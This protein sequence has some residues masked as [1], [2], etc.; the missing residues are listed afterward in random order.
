MSI[1]KAENHFCKAKVTIAFK[2]RHIAFRKMT[3]PPAENGR[4]LDG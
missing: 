1:C 3:H 4:I 2:T